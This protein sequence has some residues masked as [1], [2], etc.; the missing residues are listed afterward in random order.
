MLNFTFFF[1]KYNSQEPVSLQMNWSYLVF[2]VLFTKLEEFKLVILSLSPKFHLFR[3]L[4]YFYWGI[5]DIPKKKLHMV[6]EYSLMNLD[7]CVYLWHHHH[8]QDNKHI[9]Q[10]YLSLSVSLRPLCVCLTYRAFNMRSN[11]LN[12]LCTIHAVSYRHTYSRS[13]EL[14]LIA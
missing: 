2:L 8:N 6:N 12:F 5:I 11:L 1:L 4:K 3:F 14:I 13:L 10:L 7:V 9:Y